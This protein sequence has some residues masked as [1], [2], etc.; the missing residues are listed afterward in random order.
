MSKKAAPSISLSSKNKGISIIDEKTPIHFGVGMLAGM[1]GMNASMSMLTLVGIEAFLV[2]M[3]EENLASPFHTRGGQSHMNQAADIIVG[4]LGVYYGEK[5]ARERRLAQINPL[6]A[7]AQ[8]A[9]RTVKEQSA[10]AADQLATEAQKKAIVAADAATN[11][12]QQV[13]EDLAG[14][15][16]Y[17]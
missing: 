9:T 16:K 12:A 15:R 7:T 13:R 5:I 6:I 8:K 14:V 17:W 11:T 1:S 2:L 3:E 10:Q 4:M